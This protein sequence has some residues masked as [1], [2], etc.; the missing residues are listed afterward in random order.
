MKGEG[1]V[2]KGRRAGSCS[3]HEGKERV[4]YG[5]V[6]IGGGQSA[7]EMK[8]Q[9]VRGLTP[10]YSYKTRST[11]R[12]E[13]GQALWLQYGRVSSELSNYHSGCRWRQDGEG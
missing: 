1:G 11:D 10:G 9:E 6:G 13:P 12:G 3:R 2:A 7:E 5:G 8:G 4:A